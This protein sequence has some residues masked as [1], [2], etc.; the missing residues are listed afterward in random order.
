MSK[1]DILQA[2][3]DGR[4][5]R[6]GILPNVAMPRGT[7]LMIES[8][9]PDTQEITWALAE[10]RYDG[11]VSRDVRIVTSGDRPE[12]FG[13]PRT[14][15]EIL[16]GE[17]LETPFRA[18]DRGTIELGKSLVVEGEDYLMT[19]GAGAIDDETESGTLLS[20]ENGKFCVAQ[21]GQ[22]AS[23]RL[24]SQMSPEEEGEVRITVEMLN[25]V[26]VVGA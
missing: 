16:W 26:V 7:A 12:S 13:N 1:F 8:R 25:G 23:F 15:S 6:S 10:G 18:G 3:G 17:G 5:L 9:D 4:G 2:L 22:E 20:F 19:S 11:F 21:E 14:D 24:T